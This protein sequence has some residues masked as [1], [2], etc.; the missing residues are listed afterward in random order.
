MNEKG[1]VL[2]LNEK[3][4]TIEMTKDWQIPPDTCNY[5]IFKDGDYMLAKNG[6]TGKIE[7]EDTELH[8]VLNATS[9]S[10]PSDPSHNIHGWTKWY[11]GKPTKIV[12]APDDYVLRGKVTFPPG[13]WIDLGGSWIDISECNDVAFYFGT[14][15][16]KSNTEDVTGMCN[17]VLVG[18]SGYWAIMVENVAAGFRL[19][20]VHIINNDY[21]T[22]LKG[23]VY[24]A[25]ISDSDYRWVNNAIKIEAT[26]DDWAVND[27]RLD[28]LFLIGN[29][30]GVEVKRYA[31]NIRISNTWFENYDIGIKTVA[32]SLE[33]IQS[34][35]AGHTAGILVG[36]S[37]TAESTAYGE[38]SLLINSG[39]TVATLDSGGS[40]I[41][42]TNKYSNIRADG[43]SINT[44]GDSSYCI[45]NLGG[46]IKL[47]VT[48]TKFKVRGNDSYGVESIGYTISSGYGNFTGN[49]FEGES[50]KTGTYAIATGGPTSGLLISGN[51]FKWFDYAFYAPN[52]SVIVGN[53]YIGVNNIVHTLYNT[54]YI[55]NVTYT[56]LPDPVPDYFKNRSITV[57]DV[58]GSITGTADSWWIFVW[59]GSIWRKTQLT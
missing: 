14:S 17:G 2:L 15:E 59:D 57:H 3:G 5:I 30:V 32:K 6:R 46:G 33:I 47:N 38:V 23:N 36:E 7:F 54:S 19:D 55:E 44:W 50:G 29:D 26:D 48:G 39:T 58:D 13:V 22:Y 41:L 25:V 11:G 45:R 4:E 53:S 27:V 12:F 37:T 9:Q 49:T 51:T 8:K 20:K 18:N 43:A 52:N 28:N 24:D 56:S 16:Q 34:N 31:E 42:V 21:G 35:V 1:Y 40:G 10:I